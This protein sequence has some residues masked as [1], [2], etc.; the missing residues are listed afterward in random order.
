[1]DVT[2]TGERNLSLCRESALAL[3]RL[4]PKV[5]AND[6]NVTFDTL[7][8]KLH[9]SRRLL[10]LRFITKKIEIFTLR[11]ILLGKYTVIDS[12]HAG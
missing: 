10:F 3:Q 8:N 7:N 5:S 4:S 12:L 6:Q 9:P 11:Y 1:M 2:D